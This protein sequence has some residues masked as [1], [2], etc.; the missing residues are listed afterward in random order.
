MIP[1]GG[2]DRRRRYRDDICGVLVQEIFAWLRAA[3][4]ECTTNAI[5]SP[6]LWKGAVCFGK[7]YSGGPYRRSATCFPNCRAGGAYDRNARIRHDATFEANKRRYTS[8]QK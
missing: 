2:R 8:D 1:A 3:N 6:P 4:W 7:L 5:P